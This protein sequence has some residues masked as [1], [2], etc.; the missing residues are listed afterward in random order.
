M[1]GECQSTP[2]STVGVQVN[3]WS[4]IAVVVDVHERQ[5][6]FYVNGD[7]AGSTLHATKV[8]IKEDPSNGSFSLGGV[9]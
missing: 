9:S 8:A 3:V 4:H 2:S 6:S 1:D 5:V 7:D